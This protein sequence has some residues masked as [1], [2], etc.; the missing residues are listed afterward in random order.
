M[1][2]LYIGSSGALSL[3]PFKKL[4]SSEYNVSAVGVFN[5][6]RL[7][8]KIIALENESL[9]LAANQRDIPIIDLSQPIDIIIQQ[10]QKICIDVIL[11]SCYSKRLPDEIINIPPLGCYNLHPSLLPAYRGPEPVFWQMKA[12][13]DM[14]VSWHR[15]THDFDAGDIYK[16]KKVLLNEGDNYVE[17]NQ[18]LAKV[19]ANLMLE[20]LLDC[21]NGKHV[22][23][24]QNL[25]QASYY[26]YPQQKDFI[27]EVKGTAQQAYDFICSTKKF[28]LP[29]KCT[30]DGRTYSLIDALDY[31]NNG[32]L[33]SVEIQGDRLYIPFMRG[34]LIARFTGKVAH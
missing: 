34:V 13:A 19:G 32:S 21:T 23:S 12:G 1:N 6:I 8:N 31:D 11:M 20:L 33:E 10:C 22:V 14:G 15:V 18:Q 24:E 5:P 27:V 25:E 3:I 2:I 4:L 26:P 9:S 17:I 16:Q 28:D 30:V 29:F 7:N